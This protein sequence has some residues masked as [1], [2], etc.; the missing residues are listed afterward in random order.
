MAQNST[1]PAI[2]DH[3]DRF[4]YGTSRTISKAI[5]ANN[6]RTNAILKRLVREGVL[7]QDSVSRVYH[8]SRDAEGVPQRLGLVADP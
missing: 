7:M 2:L 3:L 6:P 1:V 8:P 4:G 5:G